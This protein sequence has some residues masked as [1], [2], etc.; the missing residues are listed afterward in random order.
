VLHNKLTMRATGLAHVTIA[1]P[2]AAASDSIAGGR[3]FKP[4]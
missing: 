3:R 4:S 2:V 1:R